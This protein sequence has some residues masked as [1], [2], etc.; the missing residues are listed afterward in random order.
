M[1]RRARRW[2]RRHRPAVTG[3][4]VALLAGLIGLA[5]ATAIYLQQRQAQSSRLALALREVNLLRGQAEADPEG[6]PVKWHAVQQ[7]V[8]R[9]EDLL[10]P[11]IDAALQRRVRDLGD[12]VSAAVQSAEREAK[13]LREAVDIRSAKADDPD[14]SASDAAYARVFRDAELDI[15]RLGPE[16]AG[17]KIRARP[18][19]VA[20]ALTAALDD[21]AAQR[22]MA[23]PKNADGWKRLV[24]TARRADADETRDQLRQLWSE[25]DRKVQREPLVKLAKEAD[26]RSWPPASLTLLAG[27]LAGAG[28]GQAAVALLRRA[29]AEHPGDV[30][31]N[32]NLAQLLEQLH[33]PRTEEAI[34]YY[35]VARAVRPET[36]HELG[37][38][39]ENRG[40]GDEA[41]VVFRDLTGR[42]SENGRHW[43]C[44][45]SL[46]QQRGD[47]AG[48]EAALENAVA[49]ARQAIR[50]KPDDAK[51]HFDLGNALYGQGKQSEG[52]A[53]YREAI[54]L[55]P[56]DAL[57]HT[58]LGA[59]LAD[60]G[61]PAEAIAEYRE[62]IRIKPD[63]AA[64][65]NNLGMA[66]YGQ[67][68]QSEGI[69][70]YRE[71]IRIKPNL[72][73]AHNN[74]GNALA[75]QGKQAEAMAE[76][77]EA[78]RIRPDLAES[79]CNLGLLLQQQGQLREALDEL[80]RGHEL[81]S[82]RPG[83]R[84][85][86]AEWVRRAQR[87][88]ELESR[89]PAVLHGD[90]KPKDAAERIGYA[91]LSSMLKQ[92]GPS[93]RLYAESLGADPKLAEDMKAGHRYNA[94]CAAALAGAGQGVDKPPLDEQ[95]QARWRKQALDW[96]K[97]DMA[98]WAKQANTGKPE[99]KA[100][101]SQ[102]L[103]HWKADT[104]LAGIRDETAIKALPDDEQKACRALWSEVDAL[105]AKAR[106]GTASRPHR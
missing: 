27:A 7:A 83:W 9:A 6:D 8:K 29:Q 47:R 11:L 41:A 43:V 57:A 16:A 32:Y 38:A 88:V 81:G 70:E 22:R 40:L 25:P 84:Y 71:A 69:A 34:R 5:A 39:L 3:A 26:P 66:L 99:A 24:A 85:P 61:K 73:A 64:A 12:Q 87:M 53:E 35:S 75:T 52:I 59:A 46:L 36:A 17:V 100:W 21:W 45:G 86:S 51:A 33:P 80:R 95:E 23:R 20:L 68:K 31:V 1:A 4:A 30:W 19:G 49:A 105:L 77:R 50:L 106:A 58:N 10:G 55:R 93:A 2:A 79:H 78:I 65:H 92:F 54:R 37:H 90:D 42:R 44:L 82:K 13:L 67:R 14:G 74:L 15:D 98:F 104:D 91:E 63:H 76:Y 60:Q 56:D 89:L 94:A 96:L 72:V 103:Q 102:T 48:G 18:A 28:E 101:V 62:A 97:T